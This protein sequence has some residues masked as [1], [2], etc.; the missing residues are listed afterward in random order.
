MHN[1]GVDKSGK[2]EG[3][4]NVGLELTPLGNSSSNDGGGGGGEGKLEEPTD[5]AGSIV[6][7]C[8]DKV[9]VTNEGNLGGISTAVGKGVT[10]SPESNSTSTGV[11]DVLE[12]DILDVLSTDG[13]STK[14]GK[15]SLHEEN[16]CSGKEEVEDIET[17]V[18]GGNALIKSG[19]AC[20]DGLYGGHFVWLFLCMGLQC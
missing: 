8:E 18:G 5:Q 4:G 14:H 3:V 2:H 16:H 19:D 9:G 10:D 13:S 11:Q 17:S 20:A 7:V 1:N 12:H 6:D 15:T